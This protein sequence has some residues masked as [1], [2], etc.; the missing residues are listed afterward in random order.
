MDNYLG[1]LLF[2]DLDFF[3]NTKPATLPATQSTPNNPKNLVNTLYPNQRNN[4]DT[5]PIYLHQSFPAQI[6]F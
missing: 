6:R 3:S 5:P 1:T 2:T 4:S